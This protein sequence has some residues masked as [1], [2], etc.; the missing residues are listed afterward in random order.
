MIEVKIE[1]I[2]A[3]KIFIQK[4][5]LNLIATFSEEAKYKP[6]RLSG[7]VYKLKESSYVRLLFD[8]C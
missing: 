7:F 2:L 8:F 1:N 6:E 4:F 5:F 3:F